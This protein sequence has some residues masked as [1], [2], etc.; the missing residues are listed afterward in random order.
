MQ[1]VNFNIHKPPVV[2]HVPIPSVWY[3]AAQVVWIIVSD[4]EDSGVKN[5][6]IL[7]RDAMAWRLYGYG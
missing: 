6:M 2:G 3:R 1:F 7:C 5:S 4:W